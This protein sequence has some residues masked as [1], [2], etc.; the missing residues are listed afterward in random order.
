[1]MSGYFRSLA[2]GNVNNHQGCVSLSAFGGGL[3]P[4]ERDIDLHAV[5]QVRSGSGGGFVGG[6]SRPPTAAKP[7][8]PYCSVMGT[9]DAIDAS[10]LYMMVV[11]SSSGVNGLR[12]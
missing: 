8:Y 11:P 6:G 4:P 9:D 2:V 5:A 3:C 12:A 1:M 7:L 10:S